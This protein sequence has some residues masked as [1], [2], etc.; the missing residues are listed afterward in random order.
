MKQTVERIPLIEVRGFDD[1]QFDWSV[2]PLEERPPD[3]PRPPR[4]R[5]ATWVCLGVLAV[6]LAVVVAAVV[7]G[8]D[9]RLPVPEA[10]GRYV[11]DGGGLR[12]IA[13]ERLTPSK[14]DGGF[15]IWSSGGAS[16][17]T[18]ILQA[19]TDATTPYVSIDAEVRRA[20]GLAF[21]Q[22]MGL[23]DSITVV[24]EF[25]SADRVVMTARGLTDPDVA[26]LANGLI[27]LRAASRVVDVEVPDTTMTRMGLREVVR[28]RWRDDALFGGVTSHVRYLDHLGNEV[29]LRV[30]D[31]ALEPSLVTLGHLAGAEP[32]GVGDRW[33][34]V[35]ADTGRPVVLWR[36]DGRLL[37]LEGPGDP[38]RLLNWSRQVRSMTDGE[39][40]ATYSTLRSPD[41]VSAAVTLASGDGWRVAVSQVR[42][43]AATTFRWEI[44]DPSRPG[45]TV[46]LPVRFRPNVMPFADRIVVGGATYVF[47]SAPSDAGGDAAVVTHGA[48]DET[49]LRLRKVFP[50][51]AILM[52]ALRVPEPGPV[53]VRAS[54]LLPG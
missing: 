12:P 3:R 26:I 6:V 29:V 45:V 16:A 8:R 14:D 34:A 37:S 22:S 32:I 38:Q 41:T 51:M 2:A 7:A 25:G 54:G 43:G 24:R 50:D 46:T 13:A 5:P 47:V 39:W 9:Q 21:V 1:D 33:Y 17:A 30:A 27:L 36:E 11:V 31:G 35:P 53:L 10:E 15:R 23:D 18:V 40:T 48:G 4:T 42:R 28:A 20:Q 19:A 44:E 49:R 52:G